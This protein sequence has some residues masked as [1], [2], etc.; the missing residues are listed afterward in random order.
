MD[1]AEAVEGVRSGPTGPTVG[2]FFDFDDTIVHG[3]STLS[4]E[5]GQSDTEIAES[6]R[7]HFA[8]KLAG[9][10]YPEVWQLIRA[11][12]AA[13]H[14]IVIASPVPQFRIAPVADALGIEHVLSTRPDTT[15]TVREFAAERNLDLPSSYGYSHSDRELLAVVGTGVAVN[16]VD[17]RN[18]FVVFRERGRAKPREV[19]R[20]AAG[21]AGFFGGVAAGGVEGLRVRDRRRS[22]DGMISHAGD[23]AL[24]FAKIDVAV[25]GAHNAESPRPAVFIFNHQSE[26]DLIV[27]AK[28]LRHG[29]TG[30]TKKELATSPLFG[31]LLRFAGATFVDRSNTTKA[32][33]ALAPV[34]STLRGGLSVVI[35][36]EGTRSLT[37]TLGPFKKGAF[38]IAIQAEVPI[39]PVVIRNAGELYWK[40]AKTARAGRVDVAVL[41]PIY[42]SNWTLD[43]L[44]ERVEQVRELFAQT[45]SHWPES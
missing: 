18:R 26:L 11:H 23:F 34:V 39:I 10:L 8:K 31:P 45:L 3:S 12:E 36:P 7:R 32:K 22:V 9:F 14:T 43:E 1:I 5:D 37:P 38:H 40:N 20:T 35:A 17:A 33:E 44:D 30:I 13:G 19:F 27:L 16:P 42:V 4:I 6:A 21:L 15:A 24:K 41:D 28:V 2:V 29:F 25:T